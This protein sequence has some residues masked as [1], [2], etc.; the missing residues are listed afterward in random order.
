MAIQ[1]VVLDNRIHRTLPISTDQN[2]INLVP[3]STY[4]VYLKVVNG[5]DMI[6]I[7]NKNGTAVASFPGVKAFTPPACGTRIPTILNPSCQ[8]LMQID[9][10]LYRIVELQQSLCDPGQGT[11]VI[12][13]YT[14]ASAPLLTTNTLIYTAPAGNVIAMAD[15][16]LKVPPNLG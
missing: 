2:L 13:S 8:F 4:N 15:G 14:P 1:D 10:L 16:G 6:Y 7:T 9:D 3:N 5:K 12:Q 11:L